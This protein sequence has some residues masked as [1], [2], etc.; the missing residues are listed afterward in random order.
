MLMA[1]QVI[2]VAVLHLVP[3][4]Q[5]VAVLVVFLTQVLAQAV[6][7]VAVVVIVR[8]EVQE[9]R[10]DTHQQKATLVPLV[11][12]VVVE[13]H[14]L[15]HLVKMVEQGIHHLLLALLMF[16]HLVVVVVLPHLEIMQELVEQVQVMEEQALLTMAAEA[17]VVVVL[18][19]EEPIIMKAAQV[20]K[21]Q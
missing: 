17:A 3:Q 8:L 18:P 5:R 11:T 16:I 21:A 1:V 6:V 14:L 9:M 20:A 10:E 4:K 13:E 12:V 15:Q 7:L 2:L 19:V